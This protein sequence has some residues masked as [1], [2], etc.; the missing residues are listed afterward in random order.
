MY[1]NGKMR[2]FETISGMWRGRIRENNGGDIF[3]G[4]I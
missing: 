1:V 3:G 4:Y 2:S